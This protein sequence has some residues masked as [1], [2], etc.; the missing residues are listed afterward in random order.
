HPH[1]ARRAL[2]LRGP[3]RVR[4]QPHR[5]LRASGGTAGGD[6]RQS[7]RPPGGMPRHQR[8]AEGRPVRSVLRLLQH[9]AGDVRG[10]AGILAGDD[11]NFA[12]PTAEIAVMGP[13]GAVN[14]LY[15]REAEQAGDPTSFK[16][17]KAREYREMLATPYVAAEH[18]YIDEVIEPRDTRARLCEVLELL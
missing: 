18:G 13:E 16:A 4:A 2:L 11:A 7:T 1:G 12:Y 10:R 8:V 14:I 6:R 17:E 3:R 5:R 15:R 9:S